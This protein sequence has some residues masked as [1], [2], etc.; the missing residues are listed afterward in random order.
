METARPLLI[1]A[2]VVLAVA[3]SN[4]NGNSAAARVGGAHAAATAIPA[5]RTG[6]A[7]LSS[8]QMVATHDPSHPPIDCPL[9]KQ[10][11]DPAHLQPFEDTAKY[12]AFLERP[13]R[14]V[15]TATPVLSM[16]YPSPYP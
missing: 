1:V 11:L 9:R 10:G 8:G 15:P 2:C 5:P 16:Y 12:I 6:E 4:K 14:G 13:D 3:C 7:A